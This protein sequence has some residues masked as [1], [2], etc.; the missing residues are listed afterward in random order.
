MGSFDS[1]FS[2]SFGVK[3]AG[4]SL[5]LGEAGRGAPHDGLKLFLIDA[6]LRLPTKRLEC[7]LHP[8]LPVRVAPDRLPVRQCCDPLVV[9]NQS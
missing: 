6:A 8:L 7:G 2:Y 4:V 3:A 9:L 1:V 5:Y